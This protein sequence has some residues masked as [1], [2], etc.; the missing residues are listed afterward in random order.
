MWG[1]VC[2]LL[3]LVG[4]EEEEDV[5][6]IGGMLALAAESEASLVTSSSTK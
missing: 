6:S 3:E 4:E 5:A 2:F 1:V